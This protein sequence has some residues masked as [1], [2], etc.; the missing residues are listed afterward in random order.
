LQ[1]YAVA[2]REANPGALVC[3]A[4]ITGEGALIEL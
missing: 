1:R 4:F 2:V 3:A